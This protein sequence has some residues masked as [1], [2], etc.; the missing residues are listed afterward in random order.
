[1]TATVNIGQIVTIACAVLVALAPYV[2][3]IMTALGKHRKSSREFV[4]EQVRAVETTLVTR[5]DFMDLRLNKIDDSLDETREGLA[6]VEGTLKLPTTRPR[7][8]RPVV[9]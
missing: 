5:L 6:R 1:M 4:K 3:L 8:P 7:K 2:V 9:S